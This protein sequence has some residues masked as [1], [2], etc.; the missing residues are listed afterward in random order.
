M[1]FQLGVALIFIEEPSD[2]QKGSHTK[3]DVQSNFELWRPRTCRARVWIESKSKANFTPHVSLQINFFAR[4]SGVKFHEACTDR[5]FP[6]ALSI[7]PLARAT[8]T[9]F[10]APHSTLK[11]VDDA[12]RLLAHSLTRQPDSIHVYMNMSLR[13]KFV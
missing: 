6:G 13:E 2:L 12:L 4:K 1:H 3:H 8:K 7:T 9:L 11:I 5:A 10:V